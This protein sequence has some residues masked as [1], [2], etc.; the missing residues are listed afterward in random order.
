MA[1]D[2]SRAWLEVGFSGLEVLQAE[3]NSYQV[4]DLLKKKKLLDIDVSISTLDNIKKIPKERILVILKKIPDTWIEKH[5]IDSIL[6]WWGNK[7]IINRIDLLKK[8]AK[9]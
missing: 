2:F 5:Q 6:E 7:D 3:T 9:K 1:F 4:S 8:E